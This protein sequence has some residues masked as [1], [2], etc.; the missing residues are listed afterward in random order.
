M[1][2]GFNSYVYCLFYL[3]LYIIKIINKGG[4]FFY[5]NFFILLLLKFEDQ[6][7]LIGN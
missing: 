4:G 3:Y 5:I 2:M 6:I 1:I 7:I